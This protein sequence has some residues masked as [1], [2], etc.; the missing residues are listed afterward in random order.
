MPSVDDGTMSETV[1]DGIEVMK[2]RQGIGCTSG[3][4]TA[5]G[6]IT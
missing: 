2:S 3:K 4:G 1:D 5:P 6:V